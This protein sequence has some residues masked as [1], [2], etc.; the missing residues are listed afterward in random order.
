MIWANLLHV[1][2]NMWSDRDGE[3]YTNAKP[4]LR[5]ETPLWREL[6]KKMA[7][8]GMN[9][10][11]IDLGDG[12][13]YDSHPEIAVK[14]AWTTDRLRREL[15]RIRQLGLEPIPKLNFSTAHDTW[16]GPY[17]RC[18]STPTYY[19][20]CHELIEEVVSLFDKPRFFHLGYDEETA[21]HQKRYDYAVMRQHELWWHDFYF[22]IEQVENRNVRPWIWADYCWHHPDE[23][24]RKMPKSV[25]Q[26]NWYYGLA[27]KNKRAY[28]KKNL[29]PAEVYV[30]AYLDLEKHGYDQVPT[31]SNHSN[32]ENFGMTVDFCRQHIAPERLLG[33]LQTPWRFT[34]ETERAHQ[35]QAIDVVA[36][37]TWQVRDQ[38]KVARQNGQMQNG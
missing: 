22:F 32:P 9:M 30:K 4:Y 34:M 35:M 5:C 24:F 36:D 3:S 16:L 18:V 7:D 19:A 33:F 37:Q 29:E 11:V 13:R 26:S 8:V 27:F 10:V 12:I 14:R 23:F 17:S 1:G 28:T 25:L 6:L 15:A 38:W 2:T 31:G 20:V 21:G